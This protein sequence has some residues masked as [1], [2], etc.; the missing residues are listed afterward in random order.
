MGAR[1]ILKLSGID[2][3][4]WWSFTWFSFGG[5]CVSSSN[6]PPMVAMAHFSEINEFTWILLILALHWHFRWQ[7]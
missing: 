2:M 4:L 5:E 1:I 3:R 7:S 6:L